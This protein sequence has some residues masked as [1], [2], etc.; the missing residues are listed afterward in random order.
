[1]V[2]HRV[3][4]AWMWV[5]LLAG[6]SACRRVEPDPVRVF[7]SN[8]DSGEVSV[9]DAARDVVV[10]TIP[11]GRRPRGLRISPDGKLLYVAVSGAPK[12]GPPAQRRD[13][14]AAVPIRA[15]V[16]QAPATPKVTPAEHDE[17]RPEHD[18]AADGIAVVDLDRQAVV[19]TLRVGRDPEAFD[20]SPDGSTLYV[21]NEDSAQLTVVD[22]RGGTI[23]G[24][25]RVGEE[26]GGVSLSRDGRF[27][28]VTC[29]GTNEVVVVD[30]RSLGVVARVPTGGR[31]RAVTFQ[32][33][34]ARAFVTTEGDAAVDVLDAA[35]HTSVGRVRMDAA[36][37]RPMGIVMAPDGEH[38]WVANGRDGSVSEIDVGTTKVTRT[39]HGVGTRPWG[40]GA[41]PDG[42]KLYV[43]AGP[44][45]A[46]VDVER[47]RVTK[48]LAVG[49]GPWAVAVAPRIRWSA[50]R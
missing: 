15:T 2:S 26:P 34:G 1:M 20:L 10:A 42:T 48:R 17:A 33:D 50:R 32:P 5:S 6:L 28:Y 19:R 41:L 14:I 3:Q 22:T 21:S 40:I 24:T 45:L 30:A 27:V 12:G 43:A 47:G 13:E 35:S 31:P 18:E 38:A 46:V 16:R 29:E 23:R 11:V 37:A 25:V 7:V 9:V 39:L 49:S 36:S 4:T 44:D 8:E